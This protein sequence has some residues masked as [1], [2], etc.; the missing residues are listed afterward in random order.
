MIAICEDSKTEYQQLL[1]LIDAGGVS[2]S[3]EWF[4][5]GGA[6][7]AEFYPGR[8]DLVLMDIYME[9]L[10]GVETV[11][12]LRERDAS[13]P[14]AFITT[15]VDHAMDGYRL[16]VSRYLR[17]PLRSEEV[18]EVLRFAVREK[19]DL[20][21]LLLSTRQGGCHVPFRH[22]RYVEQSDHDLT[23]YLTGGRT[24]TMRGR[25]DDLERRLPVPPFYRCHKSYLVDLSQ[26]RYLDRELN[27][28][29][30]N[31]GGAAYIRRASVR[32]AARALERVLF[33]ETRKL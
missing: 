10:T 21:G 13:V 25:L 30:M 8:Y 12:R 24:L 7:L 26:V 29:V 15:S 11:S 22:I 28:F 19:M 20:P 33:D 1:S 23:L 32:D 9:G 6:F 17:K 27:T 5:T 3:C 4:E 16:R 18:E 2:C 31:E 14:V